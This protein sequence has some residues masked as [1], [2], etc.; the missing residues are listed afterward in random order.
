MMVRRLFAEVLIEKKYLNAIAEM[1][2]LKMWP[3]GRLQ[4]DDMTIDFCQI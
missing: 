3:L 4:I 2:I 1:C